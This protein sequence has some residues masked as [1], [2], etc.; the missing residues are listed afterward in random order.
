VATA[1]AAPLAAQV[2]GAA[3][4]KSKNNTKRHLYHLRSIGVNDYPD[5]SLNVAK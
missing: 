1:R 4:V 5:S 2:I 3:S